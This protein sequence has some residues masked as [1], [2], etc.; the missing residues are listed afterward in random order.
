MIIRL[1]CL[2]RMTCRPAAS[3]SPLCQPQQ[4]ANEGLMNERYRVL[5]DL[6]RC[7]AN[8]TRIYK[9]PCIPNKV[10][11][12]SVAA[13]WLADNDGEAMPVAGSQTMPF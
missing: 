10:A 1:T 8:K 12:M 9:Y 2:T 6:A 11:E 13:T 4:S 5:R 3:R 7:V